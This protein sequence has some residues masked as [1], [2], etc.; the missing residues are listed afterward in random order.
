MSDFSKLEL[1]VESKDAVKNLNK[2]EASLNKTESAAN[3]LK[4]TLKNIGLGIGFAALLK[5][6]LQLENSTNALN[7]RFKSFFGTAGSKEVRNLADDFALTDR[8]AK[9]LLSTAAKF[10]S[11]TGLNGKELTSF[12]SG[13]SQLAADVAA[14]HGLDDVNSILDRFGA[15]TMGRTQGLREFGIQID[16]TSES[17]KKQIDIIQQQTGATEAQ[18]KQLYILQEAQKQLAYTQGSAGEQTFTAWQQ[19]TNLL[20]T[21]KDIMA[22]IGTILGSVFGPFLKTLNTILNLP[23]V[24]WVVAISVVIGLVAG[25]LNKVDT[26]QTSIYNK[27][28]ADQRVSLNSQEKLAALQ[29]E[30]L[31]AKNKELSI[32]EKITKLRK[33]QLLTANYL[34]EVQNATN[35][36]AAQKY[37][38]YYQQ[39]NQGIKGWQYN[40]PTQEELGKQLNSTVER[41]NKAQKSLSG[42]M[43]PLIGKFNLLTSTVLRSIPGFDK[44]NAAFQTFLIANSLS[45]KAIKGA[46]IAITLKNAAQLIENSLKKVDLFVTKIYT[47]ALGMNTKAK[48]ANTAATVANTAAYKAVAAAA[49]KCL[50]ILA[51]LAGKLAIIAGIVLIAVDVVQII[52]QGIVKG[53]SKINWESLFSNIIFLPIVKSIEQFLHDITGGI[54]GFNWEGVEK[55]AKKAKETSEKLKQLNTSINDFKKEYESYIVSSANLSERLSKLPDYTKRIKELKK[56][57]TDDT[58]YLKYL[59]TDNDVDR[60]DTVKYAKLKEQTYKRR[61]EAIKELQKLE[62]VVEK[63]GSLKDKLNESKHSLQDALYQFKIDTSILYDRKTGKLIDNKDKT[64]L[65]IAN[66]NLHQFTK[67]FEAAISGNKSVDNVQKV[68]EKLKSSYMDSYRLRMKAL[69]NEKN[70]IL[71][72]QQAINDLV[73]NS[74]GF[75]QTSVQAV[76]ASSMRA[77]E[78]QTRERTGPSTD[79]MNKVAQQSYEIKEIN[80][81]QANLAQQSYT[82]F[83]EYVRKFDSYVNKTAG[84]TGSSQLIVVNY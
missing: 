60:L 73:K 8:A 36:G 14:F 12:S 42:N 74:V 48:V 61:S 10:G 77:L 70:K 78:L 58:K 43:D 81:Q 65:I 2:V 71:A 59:E 26:L 18:A 46:T 37:Q 15:A 44:L 50:I 32:Q 53:F 72:N 67:E 55:A 13:L 80:K 5:Q 49:A 38:E 30:F 7:K 54:I 39:K 51:K 9:E 45:L 4:S 23:V 25:A 22:K 83:T 24:Q 76:E 64:A 57:I 62:E 40:A 82:K 19:L 16:T 75:Q 31:K 63:I 28:S 1:L 69:E 84:K 56:Q 17:F 20:Q 68:F 79:V 33:E 29:E 34:K 6:S 41:L 52:Y 11:A 35:T 66:K 47:I 21:F 27:I 3:S